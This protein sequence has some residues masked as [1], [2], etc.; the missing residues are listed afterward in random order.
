MVANRVVIAADLKVGD[1]F[2]RIESEEPWQEIVSLEKKRCGT[3]GLI[4]CKLKLN[5]VFG[6]EFIFEAVGQHEV[7]VLT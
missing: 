6:G 3:H 7:E 5:G 2:R 1:R 4:A